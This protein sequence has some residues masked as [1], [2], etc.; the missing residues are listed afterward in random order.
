MQPM[1]QTE[2]YSASVYYLSGDF[3]WYFQ[4]RVVHCFRL[5]SRDMGLNNRNSKPPLAR[6]QGYW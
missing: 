1:P 4:Y 5:L 6:L 3:V 2:N